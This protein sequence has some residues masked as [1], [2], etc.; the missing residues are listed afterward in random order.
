MPGDSAFPSGT[1]SFQ[2]LIN[3][4]HI[5][6]PILPSLLNMRDLFSSPNSVVRGIDSELPFWM[7]A[8]DCW[9]LTLPGIIC[10]EGSDLHLRRCDVSRRPVNQW[11]PGRFHVHPLSLS[12][13]TEGPFVQPLP[14]HSSL[15]RYPAPPPLHL[16]FTHS[17][18]SSQT[19]RMGLTGIE[20]CSITLPPKHNQQISDK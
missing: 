1:P 14:H 15:P 17:P 10:G 18:C 13:Q 3:Y 11:V 2:L 4:R 8:V 5:S 9:P 20:T 7:S 12:E 6:H 16:C 19:M